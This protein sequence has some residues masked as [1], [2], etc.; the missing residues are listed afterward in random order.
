MFAPVRRD[1]H[2]GPYVAY[3]VM[4]QMARAL[5]ALPTNSEEL[6]SSEWVC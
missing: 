3:R 5:K 6:E 2:A 4:A 1:D